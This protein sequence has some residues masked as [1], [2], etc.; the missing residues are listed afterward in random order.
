V[1]GGQRAEAEA[2]RDFLIRGGITVA[3][4]EPGKKVENLFL[5]AGNG[6]AGIVAN[7]QRIASEKSGEPDWYRSAIREFKGLLRENG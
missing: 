7:K 1:D 6:H 2:G 5:P 3:G 4:S